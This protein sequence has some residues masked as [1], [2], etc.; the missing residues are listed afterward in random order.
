MHGIDQPPRVRLALFLPPQ[1]IT[2]RRRISRIV[3]G[4][5]LFARVT[6]VRRGA[7]RALTVAKPS[8]FDLRGASSVGECSKNDSP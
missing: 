4:W 3:A 7:M 1:H 2:P 8:S 6:M 5:R